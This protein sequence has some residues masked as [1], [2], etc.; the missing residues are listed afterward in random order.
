MLSP[1]YT[2]IPLKKSKTKQ[3]P[4][5]PVFFTTAFIWKKQEKKI[6]SKALFW[7]DMMIFKK[8]TAVD[9]FAFGNFHA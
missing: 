6:E 4:E 5:I 9:H 2:L 8:S 1:A 3:K 7:E